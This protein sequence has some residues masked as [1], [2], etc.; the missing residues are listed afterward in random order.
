MI[1]TLYNEIIWHY[2]NTFVVLLLGVLKKVS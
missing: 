2:N 1:N